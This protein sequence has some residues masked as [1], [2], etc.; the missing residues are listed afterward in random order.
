VSGRGLDNA[1]P[2]RSFL[3]RLRGP[4]SGSGYSVPN[5][6]H[7]IGPIRPTRRH[8]AI[9]PHGGLYAMPSL[10]GSAKATRKWFRAFTT[11]SFLACRPLRP[12]GVRHQYPELR[13]RYCLRR[14]TNGSALPT[15]PQSVPHGRSISWLHWF[16]SA[17][18]CRVARPPVRIR[19]DRPAFG[20]FYF[21]AFNGSVSLSVAGYNYNSDWTPLL[22]GLSPAGMAASLAA[23]SF[24]TGSS[25]QQARPSPLYPESGS[26][27]DAHWHHDAR[28][29]PSVIL[30]FVKIQRL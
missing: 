5:R 2:W 12:R 3:L 23:R 27:G 25:P 14:M 13:C 10:C 15:L 26:D 9:S 8:I 19:L 18:A 20:D 6:H 28:G 24:A 7:L 16:A 1:P 17:T 11:H 4:R 22:A 30:H 21:Q 29:R